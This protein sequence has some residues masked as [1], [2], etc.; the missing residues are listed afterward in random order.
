MHPSVASHSHAS[1][2]ASTSTATSA[3]AGKRRSLLGSAR[4]HSS[5]NHSNNHTGGTGVRHRG[6]GRGGASGASGSGSASASGSGNGNGTGSVVPQKRKLGPGGGGGGARHRGFVGGS[7]PEGIG[8]GGEGEGAAEE[9]EAIRCRCGSGADDGFSIACDACGRWCHAACFGVQKESVPEEWACWVCAPHAHAQTTFLQVNTTVGRRRASVSGRSPLATARSPLTTMTP[10]IPDNDEDE[11]GQYVLIDEDVVPDLATQRKLRAYATQWRGVSALSAPPPDPGQHTPLVFP[12]P[13]PAHPTLLHRVSP[14]SS[15]P[16][17]SPPSSSTHPHP[18]QPSVLPPSYALHTAAPAP[19]HALL[20][21]LPALI[22]P[23]DA[24]LADPTNAYAHLGA[25]KRFVHI[26]GPPLDVALD[27]RGVGGRARWAR[28]GCYPNAA[29]RA[30]VCGG[31]S[32]GGEEAGAG[33]DGGK[34]GKG[35]D[36]EGDTTTRFGLF[37]TRALAQ[38]EEV[39]VGWEWDDGNAVHRLEEVCGQGHG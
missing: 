28:R 20:A 39:V 7:A 18:T 1:T 15:Y 33:G 25:P 3:P 10:A 26:V 14:P 31:A 37:A 30:W 36:T 38:G 2:S 19:P 34:A 23:A 22:T 24:Y 5:N 6:G 11:R 35:E 21:P 29:V 8:V 9:G 27:A 32:H 13:P 12:A 4:P 16:Y 17:P